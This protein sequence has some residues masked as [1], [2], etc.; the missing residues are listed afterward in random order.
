[1]CVELRRSLEGLKAFQS[2]MLVKIFRPMQDGVTKASRNLG[3]EENHDL[4]SSVAL[5]LNKE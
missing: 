3:S 4:H 2:K 5:P 1:M